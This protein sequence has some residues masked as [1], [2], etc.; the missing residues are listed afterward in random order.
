MVKQAEIPVS[1]EVADLFLL[2]PFP[3]GFACLDVVYS[4]E[5][6]SVFTMECW[7]NQERHLGGH[8]ARNSDENLKI[9]VFHTV[10][11]SRGSE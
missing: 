9:K 8:H 5:E 11:D 10:T 7:V 4:V 1:G 2:I 3:E 6:E